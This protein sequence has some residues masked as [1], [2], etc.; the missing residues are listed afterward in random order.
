MLENFN[1]LLESVSFRFKSIFNF[2]DLTFFACFCKIVLLLIFGLPF[3]VI[4]IFGILFAL[5]SCFPIVGII[6]SFTFCLV[7]DLL[8]SLFFNLI[9]LPNKYS[10]KN[11]TETVIQ[12]KL[13]SKVKLTESEYQEVYSALSCCYGEVKDDIAKKLEHYKDK[14]FLNAMSGM[15]G[16]DL[17][18]IL[19][20]IKSFTNN[21]ML[22]IELEKAIGVLE[23]NIYK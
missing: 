11:T 1:K 20:K 16:L 10:I 23:E 19:I 13:V 17:Q 5:C 12:K 22:D 2:K 4:E 18:N 3:I 15:D 6:F 9:M 21:S 14:L 8:A 7:S